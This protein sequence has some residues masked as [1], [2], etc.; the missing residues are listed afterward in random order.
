MKNLRKRFA[1]DLC[2]C[3]MGKEKERMGKEKGN[4]TAGNPTGRKRRSLPIRRRERSKINPAFE[5]GEEGGGEG[6]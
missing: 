3:P 5:G 1:L 6:F 4:L 2:T